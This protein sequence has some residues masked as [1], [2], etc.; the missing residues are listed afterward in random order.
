MS[1][2]RTHVIDRLSA[3]LHDDT[4]TSDEKIELILTDDEANEDEL[5]IVANMLRRK[6]QEG[7]AS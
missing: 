4:L 3:V 6:A 1:E 7:G 5:G 2:I